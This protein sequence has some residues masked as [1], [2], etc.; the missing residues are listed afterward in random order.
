MS[1]RVHLLMA[2]AVLTICLA[3]ATDALAQGHIIR[4]KVRNSAGVNITQITVSL[5]SGNG[6]LIN[7]TVTNNEGDFSFSG[8]SDT[9]Y[10]VTVSAPDFIPASERVEF[11]RNI[12]PGDPGEI[13][14]VE[15]T[16]VRKDVRVPR[17]G[18]RFVQDVPEA[19]LKAFDVGV[20]L[21][22]GGR[23]QDG[24]RAIEQAVSLFPDY[25]DARFLLAGELIKLGRLDEAIKQLNEAQRINPKDDRVWS[26]FGTVL[27]RQH[28]YAVAARV[29]AE[30]AKL[31]PLD[32][33][34]HLMRATV[35]VD[36]ASTIDAAKSKDTATE[37]EQT[38]LLAE[39]SLKRVSA[40]SNGKLSAAH[41][42]LA[43]LYERKGERTRAADQLEE[44]LSLNPDAKNAGAIRDAIKKLRSKQ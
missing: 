27:A 11:V 36:H 7:Q 14:S 33:Q 26:A 44:Y 9:S 18:L 17:A 4:G 20:K 34:H 28:K 31:N 42:Q 8:L 30:A 10:L 23:A 25:F 41:L 38:L 35:L 22:R 32:P 24:Q 37:R 5:E 39:E 15:I 19:A 1:F 12:G 6:G 2:L 43:R 40:L 3:S 21:I 29:F 16:L 13:R